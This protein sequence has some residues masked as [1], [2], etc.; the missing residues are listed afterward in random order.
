M[1]HLLPI[2]LEFKAISYDL[3]LFITLKDLLV[4][5]S[6][7]LLLLPFIQLLLAF[8]LSFFPLRFLTR[9]LIDAIILFLAYNFFYLRFLILI[10]SL[11]LKIFSKLLLLIQNEI[12]EHPFIFTLIQ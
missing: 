9:L 3:L 4:L 7:L 6:D 10:I 8:L 2:I 5:L 11:L 1:N 12:K